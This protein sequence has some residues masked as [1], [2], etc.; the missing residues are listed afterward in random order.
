M[1]Q[2]IKTCC[3]LVLAAVV[4]AGARYGLSGVAAQ[5]AEAELNLVLGQLLPGSTSFEEEP[6][7]GEDTNIVA[8]YKSE[9]GYVVATVTAGYA[10]DIALLTGVSNDGEVTGVL[11]RDMQE[12]YGL[13]RKAVSDGA[14]LSQFLNTK[15]DA[16][17]GENVDALTGATVTSKAITKGIN[18]AAAFV[19]G[20]DVSSEATEW[21]G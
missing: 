12:T 18:S 10:G 4:L 6:Y 11:V 20:A 8:V 5:R 15:G 1:K 21:E 16:A 14:F 7:S 17:V 3:V 9:A 2:W 13:G 19:T